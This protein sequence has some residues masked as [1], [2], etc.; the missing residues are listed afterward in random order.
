MAKLGLGKGIDAVFGDN[1]FSPTDVTQD[2]SQKDAR[3]KGLPLEGQRVLSEGETIL[4]EMEV[5]LL[6][7]NPYQPRKDFDQDALE[8]LASSIKEHGIVEPIIVSQSNDGNFYI[9]GGERRVRAAKIAGLERVP[10]CIKQYT[11]EAML[12]IAIIENIQREDLNALEEAIAYNDLML[13]SNATQEEVAKRVG[14]SRSAVANALR[15]LKLPEDMK[16]A[17]SQGKISA[18]HARA[19][20]SVLNSQE[21]DILFAR[22]VEAELSVREA[23]QMAASLNGKGIVTKKK[24]RAR[25]EEQNPELA[26]LEEQF[27]EKLGTKVQLK[28]SLEKGSLEISYFSQEDLDH[29]FSLLCN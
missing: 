16:N 10:V 8:E 25:V 2:I 29:L 4:T 22:I 18:G 15:L 14:K 9:V 20:L 6:L 11:K 13:M 12:E 19:L 24:E 1:A 21:Q 27:R 23:E 17:L 7:P 26:Y 28:G 3:E 5:G